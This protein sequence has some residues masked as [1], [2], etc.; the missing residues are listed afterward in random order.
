MDQDIKTVIQYPVGATEFDIPF[1]YL[2]RKFVRVSLVSDDNR[3]LLSNITEYRYVS[4][5]RVKLLVETTG[6]DRV[7]IRRFT[8]A[9]ERVVDFSDG[10]VLRAVDLNVSQ[11]QSA[12]IAEEARDS[13]L[14]AMPEDD[15]GNLDARNRR[16]VR[17]APGIEG[18]DAINKDQ[19]DTTL[20]EAGGILSE[21]K[22]VQSD[23]YEYIEKFASDTSLVRGVAWIYNN[24]AAVGGE[25]NIL[26]VKPTRVFA[27]PYLEINGSR[28]EVGYH[29]TF[30]VGSQTI[31]LARPLSPGD[32]LMA[33]T[34]ESQLPL[35]SLLASTS[36]A[37]SIGTASGETVQQV[38]D[39]ATLTIPSVASLSTIGRANGKVVRT[40]GYYPGT[41]AG[42][43]VYVYD[44]SRS[45]END[46]VTVINGWVRKFEQRRTISDAG[47]VSGM[48]PLEVARRL[49]ILMSTA[50]AGCTFDGEGIR[51]FTST[52][53]RLSNTPDVEV[54]GLRLQGDRAT[55]SFVNNDRGI[56]LAH[57][58]PRLEIHGCEM[59]GVRMSQPNTPITSSIT[60]TGRIQDGDAGI[61]LKKCDD[62]YVHHNKVNGVKT[63]G[64]LSTDGTRPHVDKNWVFDCARQ[65]GISVCIGTTY[66]V[67]DATVSNNR[68][69]NVGLYAVELEK[70]TKT[71]N[72]VKVFSN[73]VSDAQYGIHAV[74]L[75]RGLQANDNRI[76]G[77]RYAMA[78]TSLN[79]SLGSEQNARNYFASNVASGNYAGIGPSNSYYVTYKENYVDGWR[80]NDYFIND[81]YD[82]VEIVASA[83]SFYSLRDLAVGKKILVNGTECTVQSSTAT[84]DP[85]IVAKI[86]LSTVYLVVC[87][88]LPAGVQDF[89]PF[90]SQVTAGTS[91][92]YWPFFQKNTGDHLID[93]TFA[94][95]RY[96]FYQT[97]VAT[98]NNDCWA[99]GTK[100]I[101]VTVPVAGAAWGIEVRRSL[102]MGCIRYTDSANK[103]LLNQ[104]GL[105][106]LPTVSQPSPVVASGSKPIHTFYNYNKEIAVRFRVR[107]NNVS[108]TTSPTQINL[109]VNLNGTAIGYIAVT[110]KGQNVDGFIDVLNGGLLPVGANTLQIVDTT[111]SLSL[112]FWHVDIF[113]AD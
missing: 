61:E 18:T 80:P 68:I 40:I 73:N 21:V 107:A 13:A 92:G 113:V 5:T 112:D 51:L 87:D 19:L 89:T 32:F 98:E 54:C 88:T 60:A 22:D 6:F 20:G 102:Y 41:N 14:M 10:S 47:I 106:Q 85:D 38:I 99:V 81:P 31:T 62:A 90:K 43:G 24:G 64:I 86:G 78:G 42:G 16:I 94:N 57:T 3:R 30:D 28:Q 15:A 59:V 33:M 49:N 23:V 109:A 74:G 71:A 11:L 2:S 63:W 27:V 34:T 8:S 91:Y 35:E 9:S 70:W 58:C 12:H 17:L 44:S 84:S 108:W 100:F 75:I 66:D 36:G 93:N 83:N 1:D 104:L 72:R 53:I 101:N 45:S 96:G 56:F 69:H 37:A 4:K 105:R 50:K 111:G 110:A 76:S 25:L 55:W 26:V 103:I 77:C 39:A 29:F 48:A 95:V 97:A 46:G 67:E 52:H 7:E 65:S 82:T 79:A